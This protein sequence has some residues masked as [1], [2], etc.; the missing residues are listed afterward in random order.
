MELLVLYKVGDSNS[1]CQLMR[2]QVVAKKR[3]H[4]MQIIKWPDLESLNDGSLDVKM[5]L[6][7]NVS[8]STGLHQDK[9]TTYM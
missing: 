6:I 9:Y 5:I 1:V 4:H 8:A 7:V 2:F 3:N